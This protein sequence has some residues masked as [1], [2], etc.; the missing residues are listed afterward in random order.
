MAAGRCEADTVMSTA[1]LIEPGPS[2]KLAPVPAGAGEPRSSWPRT[3]A[4]SVACTL[5]IALALASPLVFA[6]GGLLALALVPL[7]L[8]T[9]AVRWSFDSRALRSRGRLSL[10][11]VAA[12]IPAAA[13]GVAIMTAVEALLG[14]RIEPLAVLLSLALTIAAT[15]AA[16]AARALELRVRRASRMVY[17]VGSEEQRR[18][19]ER[20]ARRHGD[21]RMVG[22]ARV[23]DAAR[24]GTDPA[25][26]AEQFTR[27]GASSLVLSAEAIRDETICAAA[28]LCNLEGRRVRALGSFYEEQ[29]KRIPLSDLTP[30]WFLFDIAEIHRPRLYAASK[31]AFEMLFAGLMLVLLAPLLA[32]IAGAV[33]ISS[34]GPVLFRQTRVGRAGDPFTVVKFRTM[35]PSNALAPP[36]WAT[37]EGARVTR[38]GRWLRRFRLDELPQLWNVLRGQLSLIGPRPEQVEIVRDL[39][40]RIPYYAARHVVRPG[41]TGWA[42]VSCGYGGSIDGVLEKLQLD[43]YYVKHQSLRLDLLILGS[44]LR[45]VLLGHD[46]VSAPRRGAAT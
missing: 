17:L 4:A 6:D 14:V 8:A 42:Q 27:A 21:M 36:T 31:R 46:A 38:A 2:R 1:P 30:S 41:L 16:A 11:V 40:A 43:L 44:T 13:I 24:A 37:S 39:E 33:A 20:Q 9:F 19:L 28:S 18:D 34:R 25:G 35:R 12:T 3:H 23:G 26:L 15:C 29:F 45:A 5:A 32:L 7:C 10:L 22:F